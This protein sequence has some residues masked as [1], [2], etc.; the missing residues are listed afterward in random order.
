MRNK[1]VGI[2]ICTLLISSTTTLALTPFSRIEQQTKN[3]VSETTS[4]LLP[5]STG[6][7]KTF[8]G[9]NEDWAWS[10]RQT[11]D[12]GYIITGG[13]WSFGAGN[14]DA[15]LIKTD[16]NG[17]KVWDKTFGGGNSD[18]SYIVQQ[19]TDGG[20]IIVGG[21]DSFGAGMVDVWLIKTDSN[22][23]KVWD[24]TFGGTERDIA[25]CVQQTADGGYIITGLTDSFGAGGYDFWLIKTNGNGDEVWNRTF[26]GTND[27]V[28][29]SVQQTTDD[30]YIIVGVTQS[31]GAGQND[32]WLIK[33]NENG[34]KVWDRTF[35]GI[36]NDVGFSVQQ[37]ADGA[38]IITGYTLSFDAGRGDGWLIKTDGDGNEQWNRTFGGTGY[39]EGA[40]VQQTSDG[41]YIIVGST[42]SFNTLHSLDFWLIKTDDNGNKVWDRTFGGIGDD[43]GVF[44]QQTSDGGYI[45]T[46][47][48]K[49]YGAGSFDVWLIKTDSEGKSKTTSLDNLWFERIFQRFP[50]TIPLLRHLLQ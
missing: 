33:I 31:F 50:N 5:T 34:N 1:I 48:T 36:N 37:T 23:N 3:Q 14:V 18:E 10:V 12:G 6:W 44:V 42:S 21:T 49:S 39:D 32:V 4:V 41:E 16:S 24:R 45:I 28:G 9:S 30:G 35:G 26:G 7:M 40:S 38:F 15:W 17:D 22:G 43:E 25:C 20:Y 19:T 46:G 2:V 27:D 11:T 13:T 47:V 29:W 8:G